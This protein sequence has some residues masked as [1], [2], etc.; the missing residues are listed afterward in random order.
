MLDR[1]GRQA[2]LVTRHRAGVAAHLLPIDRLPAVLDPPVGAATVITPLPAHPEASHP[3]FD[4]L[5]RYGIDCL[6]VM[7]LPDGRAC[8]GPASGMPSF[9][10][11]ADGRVGAPRHA[12][13]SRPLHEPRTARRR[14]TRL[15]RLDAVEQMLP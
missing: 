6:L 3:V 12:S 2:Q 5:L 14:L 9:Y 4:R 1:A 15:A 8:S 10:R 7:P 11:R 13:A